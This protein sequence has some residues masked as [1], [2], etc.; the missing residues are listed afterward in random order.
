[1]GCFAVRDV[2]M[3]NVTRPNPSQNRL[4]S[5]VHGPRLPAR[6][7]CNDDLAAARE[8]DQP[9]KNEL[10]VLLVFLSADDQKG[11]LRPD[12]RIAGTQRLGLEALDF[13]ARATLRHC[14][15]RW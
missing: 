6:E 5:L 13:S 7:R 2:E 1:M 9:A 3:K 15:V 10:L 12:A 11:S 4:I 8:I 14:V